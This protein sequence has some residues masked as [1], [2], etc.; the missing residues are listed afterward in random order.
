[1]LS[2]CLITKNEE[3]NIG[4]CLGSVAWAD[5]IIVVDSGS[6]DRT[7]EIARQFTP[8]VFEKPFVNFA[9][10]KNFAISKA[11]GNWVFLIDADERVTEEL[12]EEIRQTSS[13]APNAV[14]EVK[15]DTFFM[16]G[17]LRFSGTQND[18]PIRLFPKDKVRYEQPVHEQIVTE[19]AVRRLENTLL[20]LTTRNLSQ[21]MQKLHLYTGLE[22]AL[23][24]KQ[25]K[26]AG[27]S[28]LWLAPAA[29]FAQLY[30]LKA[31]ILDGWTGLR[32]AALSAYYHRVKCK[33]LQAL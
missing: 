19:L 11:A 23:M 8:K 15:R 24:K 31:G 29:R 33:K 13:K 22:A 16:G 26:K 20:H 3:A 10:Q 30:F 6:T 2:V 4:E 27:F 7:Q 25:G 28:N 9:D 1:M 18:A 17:R 32:F 14:F 12:A 5:E 21:Y